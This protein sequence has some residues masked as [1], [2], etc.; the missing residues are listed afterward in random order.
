MKTTKISLNEIILLRRNGNIVRLSNRIEL[1]NQ[2]II[3]IYHEG[4]ITVISII[5]NGGGMLVFGEL[6][7]TKNKYS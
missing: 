2:Y 6:C 5:N 1:C 3:N 4:S 7:K